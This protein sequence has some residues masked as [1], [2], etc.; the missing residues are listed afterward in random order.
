MSSQ[1]SLKTARVGVE[2]FLDAAA[3]WLLVAIVALAPLP[4][5]SN[6]PMP[7]AILTMASGLCLALACGAMLLRREAGALPVPASLKV[8]IACFLLVGLWVLIQLATF[9]PE[10]LAHP[11]WR[12]AARILNRPDI[13]GR[14]TLD[15]QSTWT[16]LGATAGYFAI[17]MAAALTVRDAR[18]ARQAA[19]TLCLS[20]G[21]YAL[22][23]LIMWSSGTE[24][25][26]WYPKIDYFG[27]VTATFINRNSFATYAGLVSL[28]GF[29][30]LFAELYELRHIAATSRLQRIVRIGEML[31][32]RQWPVLLSLAALLPALLFT[33]SR[34]GM[35]A[36]LV[37]AS[38][39]L[40]LLTQA[41]ILPRAWR[42]RTLLVFLVSAGCAVF[43]F[44]QTFVE[45]LSNEGV[46]DAYRKEAW[47]I[48]LDGIKTSPLLGHGFGAFPEGFPLYRDD[49]L[50][51]RRFWDKAH[52]TY[53]ELAFDLGLPATVILLT[54][55][56]ALATQIWK[57]LGRRRRERRMLPAVGLAALALGATHSLVD[58]SLQIP[59]DAALFA[60]LLGLAVAESGLWSRG[61]RELDA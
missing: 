46:T 38:V 14:I 22:Y 29:G 40:L 31:L 28:V 49:R 7:S 30:L 43:L 10:P 13:A 42:W 16:T 60:C 53:L 54:G 5:A 15:A 21:A 8:A 45:R 48:T 58:F 27:V 3:F 52:D 56:V 44:G 18:R 35:A 12:D 25:V 1:A 51:S 32:R 36:F 39:L 6:R 11:L 17:A 37:G 61:R 47:S 26:L 59:A 4:L 20:G 50:P 2:A 57:G 33:L 23:G 19:L 34:G 9:L 55:F 41:S 24:M